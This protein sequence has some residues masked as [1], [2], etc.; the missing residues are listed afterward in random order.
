MTSH[1]QYHFTCGESQCLMKWLVW[2]H[3]KQGTLIYEQS[4]PHL[5]TWGAVKGTSR[6]MVKWASDEVTITSARYL[7]P[8]FVSDS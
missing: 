4:F 6:M 1:K 8:V 2:S 5:H 3:L 7:P